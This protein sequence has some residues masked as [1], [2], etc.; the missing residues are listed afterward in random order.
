MAPAVAAEVPFFP[1]MPGPFEVDPKEVVITGDAKNPDIVKARQLLVKLQVQATDALKKLEADSQADVM[2]MVEP[3]GLAELFDATNKLNYILDDTSQAG[4]QRLRRL[5]I[6][7]KY[8]FED[9]A[10]LPVSKKGVVQPRGEK[11]LARIKEC[12]NEYLKHSTR[13]LQYFESVPV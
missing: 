7:A 13:L 5:M 1:S 3:F 6:Q 11:R 2:D 9:D 10:P 8:Q 12:L 4:L